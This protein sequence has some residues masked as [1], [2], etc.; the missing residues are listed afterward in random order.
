MKKLCAVVLTFLM[1]L[2]LCFCPALFASDAGVT[3]SMQIGNREM[4]VN[5]VVKEIDPGFSTTPIIKNGR[6]LMPLRA[7]MMELGG[8][9]NWI[10]SERAVEVMLGS[11]KVSL[12]IGSNLAKRNSSVAILD[13][14]PIIVGGRTMLP[15]R[16]IAESFNLSVSWNGE[17]QT[18]TI[19]SGISRA[20]FPLSDV[21][22]FCG[23]PYAVI[24]ENIPYFSDSEIT[25][26]SYEYYE[27]LD[28]LGR[29]GTC[30]ASL[31][32]DTMPTQERGSIAHIK[33]TGWHNAKYDFIPGKYIYNRCHLI[34]YQLTAENDN[35]KNIIAGTRYMN[36]EGML[37]F[38]NMVADYVKETGNHVM[39]R[40]TPIFEGDEL[41]ARGVQMEAYSVEDEGEE[42]S[43]NVYVYNVQPGVAINYAT[44]ESKE[45]DGT[46]FPTAD[47]QDSGKKGKFVMNTNSKKFHTADCSGAKNISE[48]NRQEYTGSRD[49]LIA[50]GYEPCGQCE[51]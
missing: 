12:T 49:V 27:P 28:E 31:S 8:S 43:F 7:V 16:F 3:I 6:T 22:E 24:N 5:G 1:A 30:E 26:V 2:N 41:V 37:P 40:V 36:I 14:V 42:L 46:V 9:V 38:E 17:S 13:Q 33:P 39:Y 15:I 19:V 18:I 51:P 34:G 11:N 35:P 47:E 20:K 21:P 50:Q 32:A 23:E 45:D 48:A 4:T 10:E 44:G 29:C 25:A